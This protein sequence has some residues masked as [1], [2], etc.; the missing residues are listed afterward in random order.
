MSKRERSGGREKENSYSWCGVTGMK[1]K[2]PQPE[3]ASGKACSSGL[4]GVEDENGHWQCKGEERRDSEK[5][6]DWLT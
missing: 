1:N 6:S 3:R 4:L 2:E 5:A